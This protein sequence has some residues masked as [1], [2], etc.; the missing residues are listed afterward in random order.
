MIG[1]NGMALSR[2]WGH[3]VVFVLWLLCVGGANGQTEPGLG[4]AD[5][6][7]VAPTAE[8]AEALEHIN[9][10][11][12]DPAAEAFM[13][14]GI[15]RRPLTV[16]AYV[17][18][19]R[20]IDELLAAEPVPPLVFDPR[21]VAAATHHS[22]YMIEH[23]QGH[24]ED[25]ARVGF[26]GEW[27]RD[28][29]AAAGYAAQVSGENVFAV[30]QSALQSHAAFVIDWGWEEHPGG[31]Q[32]GRSHRA[33]LLSEGFTQAGIAMLLWYDER[34]ERDH[35]SVTHALARPRRLG[36][37]VGGVVYTDR[38]GNGRF[39]A[40]EGEGGVTIVASDGGT[41]TTWES[42]AYTLPLVGPDAVTVTATTGDLRRVIA[43]PAGDDNAK[44]DW[45]LPGRV[46][47]DA[48]ARAVIDCR[49][50]D[51]DNAALSRRARL[52][53][54]LIVQDYAVPEDMSDEVAE[55]TEGLDAD[56]AASR[57]RVADALLDVSGDAADARGLIAEER[58]RFPVQALASWYQQ[59]E[60]V[61]RVLATLGERGDGLEA[62]ADPARRRRLLRSVY[63]SL[64]SVTDPGLRALVLPLLHP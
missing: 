12:A 54:W 7:G 22:A 23:G 47:R 42:G 58:R 64:E 6:T 35:W 17:D 46:Q 53:L 14:V 60:T 32:P 3:A 21:L 49:A 10:L 43:V 45:V 26:T 24:D 19:D 13:L 57:R 20:F 4:A 36:R 5:N 56:I 48:V 44:R 38:N 9:R 30:A 15:G 39:D 11:R 50:V 37:C 18:L 51:P 8:A 34:Y 52:T 28:R 33:A 2:A 31:M 41:A 59:A 63:R 62:G 25:R 40:G 16:P 27:H 1:A 55:L 61:R 29:I